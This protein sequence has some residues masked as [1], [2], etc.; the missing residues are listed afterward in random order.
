MPMSQSLRKSVQLI[1]Q[2]EITDG[3]GEII[4]GLRKP[5]KTLLQ[6]EMK[7]DLQKCK[8][9]VRHLLN[10]YQVGHS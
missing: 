7:Q 4:A 1:E 3:L 8:A 2:S 5:Q 10:F 9:L 6:L